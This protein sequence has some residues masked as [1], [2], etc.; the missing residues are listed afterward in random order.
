MPSFNEMISRTGAEALIPT[1]HAATIINGICE[2]SAVL[3]LATRLPDMSSKMLKMPVLS[4]LPMAYFVDGDT[5]LKQTTKA[6]WADQVITAEEIAVIVPVPDAVLAD[7]DYDIWALFAPLVSQA[8]GKVIDNAILHGADKP[9][10]WPEGIVPAAQEKGSILTAT[11]DGYADIM[12]PGGLIS[13]V[14]DNGYL[15]TGYL[16]S[17]GSRAYLRGVRD[18][19][20]SPIFRAGM[21]EGSDYRL[22]GSPILFPRNGSMGASSPLLIAGDWSQMVYAIR[23]DMTVTKSNQAVI[24]DAEGK[25]VMNL[26]QQDMTALRF[27]L[28]L[29]WQLPRPVSAVG[30]ENPFPFAVLNPKA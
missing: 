17:M 21:G 25:V 30:G 15:V 23:Q 13:K 16:G 22:D 12:A 28:R 5:G 3:R 18:Q 11:D 2:D 1:E 14:E 26:Y 20:G 24:T 29:G 9:A 4:S 8:F 7:A 6:E 19:A 10:S 27:V